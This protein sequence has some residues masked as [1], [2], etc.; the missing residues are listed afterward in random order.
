MRKIKKS[1]ETKGKPMTNLA[2][3]MAITLSFSAYSVE[4]V[5]YGQDDR[6]DIYEA[7]NPLYIRLAKSTAAMIPNDRLISTED[8]RVLGLTGDD[9]ESMGIC[10]SAR[11]SEQ[12]TSAN[13]SGFLVGKD[14]LVTAGHCMENKSDCSGSKWLFDYKTGFTNDSIDTVLKEN[15]YECAEIIEQVL[16]FETDNDFALIRLKRAVAGRAPLKFR[17]KGKVANRAKLVVIGHPTG[18]PTKIAD[19]AYVRGNDKENFFVSNLDT[20]GG[21]SGS[22]VFDARTGIVE[23]ILVRGE[24]DYVTDDILGCE[25]PKKCTNR[26]CR[27][28]DVT[29]ITNI[30]TLMDSAND[31]K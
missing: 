23:G 7:T 2:L 8:D 25:T 30:K 17:T 6:L 27:G 16:N 29:R 18:L 10:Q 26:N 12:K 13:C 21:N 14:L 3:L 11:F 1:D 4:K 28:E 31:R 5:V 19:G 24:N 22:P 15:V 9:L 20:F